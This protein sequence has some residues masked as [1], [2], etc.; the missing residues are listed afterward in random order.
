[1]AHTFSSGTPLGVHLVMSLTELAE[2]RDDLV[3]KTIYFALM[4][5]LAMALEKA[6]GAG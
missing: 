4:L 5:L 6:T 1:M 3:T 2:T